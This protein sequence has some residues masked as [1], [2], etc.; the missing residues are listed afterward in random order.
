[1]FGRTN[2]PALCV[3]LGAAALAAGCGRDATQTTLIVTADE[4]RLPADPVFFHRIRSP[5]DPS[6]PPE[7]YF[8][9]RPLAIGREAGVGEVAFPQRLPFV[10]A[11]GDATLR[12]EVEVGILVGTPGSADARIALA[13]RQ[14]ITFTEYVHVERDLY[15]WPDCFTDYVCCAGT[16]PAPADRADRCSPA[17]CHD[18]ATAAEVCAGG[19]AALTCSDA[20]Q[21]NPVGDCVEGEE[22]AC[23]GLPGSDASC[24][25]VS[26]CV[27]GLWGDCERERARAEELCGTGVDEDCDARVDEATCACSGATC[28]MTSFDLA[29]ALRAST[30]GTPVAQTGAMG[31]WFLAVDEPIDGVP[32]A[33][34]GTEI[35][36]LG[37][38]A[39][40]DRPVL[41]PTSRGWVSSAVV[42]GTACGAV[43][44]D[45]AGAVDPA[46]GAV[47]VMARDAHQVLVEWRAPSAASVRLL[48]DAFPFE[49]APDLMMQSDLEIHVV[50]RAADGTATDLDDDYLSSAGLPDDAGHP[51]NR[52][53]S[54][55]RRLITVTR[56]L[57]AGESIGVYV[58]PGENDTWDGGVVLR[59]RLDVLPE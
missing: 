13:Q 37:R 45:D 5:R 56:T 6:Q 25:G 2:T 20:G 41:M 33:A 59:G 3:A 29:D 15:L 53:T 50:A 57:A 16:A 23:G 21:C 7:H 4:A 47:L 48:L 14:L 46:G 10:P 34:T 18:E 44:A 28:A 24:R 40:L 39:P 12:A 26:R 19:G 52:F 58:G 36:A 51:T 43:L 27:D 30:E 55:V 9:A 11:G 35:A 32:G 54:D 38:A 49:A 17:N 8:D 1:M 22:R 31:W 42:S